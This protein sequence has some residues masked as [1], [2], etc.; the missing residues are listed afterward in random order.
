M[1]CQRL[2]TASINTAARWW[3]ATFV[4]SSS[5]RVSTSRSA[6]SYG[7][8]RGTRKW[9]GRIEQAHVKAVSQRVGA[10]WNQGS[11]CFSPLELE[12]PSVR[13]LKGDTS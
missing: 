11:Q 13:T 3:A 4:R 8:R 2:L 5:S 9:A 10:E 6:A 1:T 12:F 7:H